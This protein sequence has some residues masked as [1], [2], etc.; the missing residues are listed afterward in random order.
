MSTIW[1][2]AEDVSRNRVRRHRSTALPRRVV[3][4]SVV[5]SVAAVVPAYA[6]TRDYSGSIASGG[7]ITLKATFKGGKA[8]K[9]KITWS[10]V[11]TTCDGSEIY[12]STTSGS[13]SGVVVHEGAAAPERSFYPKHVGFSGS[14]IAW[15]VS[16]RFNKSFSSAKGFFTWQDIEAEPAQISNPTGIKATCTLVQAG[17]AVTLQNFA[18]TAS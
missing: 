17:N 14:D 16:G 4:L 18:V 1:K 3:A 10:D 8:T 7:T 15:G 13:I 11:P 2:V 9:V 5:L 6:S 12:S